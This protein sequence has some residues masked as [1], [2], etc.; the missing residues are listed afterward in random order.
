MSAFLRKEGKCSALIKCEAGGVVDCVT[1]EFSKFTARSRRI[2]LQENRVSGATGFSWGVKPDSLLTGD[3]RQHT[4]H[5][6]RGV[7]CS[8]I[9]CQTNPSDDQ[10]GMIPIHQYLGEYQRYQTKK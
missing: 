3:E 9:N 4:V 8:P 5:F 10:S 6:C 2:L 1:L 7:E